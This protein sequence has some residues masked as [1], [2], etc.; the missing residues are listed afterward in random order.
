M[1]QKRSLTSR[2][3]LS[4]SDCVRQRA[5]SVLRRHFVLRACEKIPPRLRAR[6]SL[7]AGIF[8]QALTVVRL[9][10]GISM[11]ITVLAPT[12]HGRIW[13]SAGLPPCSGKIGKATHWRAYQSNSSHRQTRYPSRTPPKDRSTSKGEGL[14]DILYRAQHDKHPSRPGKNNTGRTR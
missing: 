11:D 10:K 7:R 8:S 9:P 6:P 3:E 14:V 2:L 1:L 13:P 4:Q 12:N 5:R